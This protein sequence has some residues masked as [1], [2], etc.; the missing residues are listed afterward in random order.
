MFTI[1]HH[2]FKIKTSQYLRL[3]LNFDFKKLMHS[4]NHLNLY[5]VLQEVY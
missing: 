1:A 2:L 3:L 5:E 4:D